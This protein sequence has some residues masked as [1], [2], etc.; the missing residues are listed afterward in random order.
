MKL[1]WM[2]VQLKILNDDK[3]STPD[4]Q[5]HTY[6][7]QTLPSYYKKLNK[8]EK[9]VITIEVQVIKGV[10]MPAAQLGIP[11]SPQR[12]SEYQCSLIRL[13]FS[14]PVSSIVKLHDKAQL[15]PKH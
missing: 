15:Q 1:V 9:E 7:T 8:G 12:S 13:L 4:S 10:A 6:G 2:Q 14:K 5:A 3:D 11:K